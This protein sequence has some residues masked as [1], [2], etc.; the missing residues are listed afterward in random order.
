MQFDNRITLGNW[1]TIATMLLTAGAAYTSYV[2]TIA[3]HHVRITTI[4]EQ[5]KGTEMR[6]LTSR[7]ELLGSLRDTRTEVKEVN[8][9]LD[10]LIERSK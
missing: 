6:A 7:S 1:L 3:D 10:R 8:A 2:A 4:E 9:K 5:L